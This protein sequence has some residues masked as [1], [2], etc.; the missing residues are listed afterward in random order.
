MSGCSDAREAEAPPRLV[1]SAA[2]SGG[3]E[4]LRRALSRLGRSI[5]RDS[6]D[7]EDI[8]TGRVGLRA[9]CSPAATGGGQ[10][11][12]S[13]GL[14]VFWRISLLNESK[15]ARRLKYTRTIHEY[16]THPHEEPRAPSSSEIEAR[17]RSRRDRDH[18]I[19]SLTSCA[20]MPSSSWMSSA[21]YGAR[22]ARGSGARVGAKASFSCSAVPG[23]ARGR[24]R[25]RGRGRGRGRVKGRGRG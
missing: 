9:R 8:E 5:L 15:S 17:S 1:R 19:L 3:L 25:V 21:P 11:S 6:D 4:S 23:L 7:I 22:S 18:M 2:G 13:R 12:G 14:F 24:V 20:A 16:N 10:G